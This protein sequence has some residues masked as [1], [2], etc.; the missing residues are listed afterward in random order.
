MTLPIDSSYVTPDIRLDQSGMW[1]LRN[2]HEAEVRRLRDAIREHKLGNSNLSLTN[3]KLWGV[4]EEAS[5]D[6]NR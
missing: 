3:L 6:G 2:Y 1:V 5:A 4:L